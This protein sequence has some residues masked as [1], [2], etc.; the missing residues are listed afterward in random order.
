MVK[1]VIK[2]SVF[3]LIFILAISWILGFEFITSNFKISKIKKIIPID[4]IFNVKNKSSEFIDFEFSLI[5]EEKFKLKTKEVIFQKFSN[6][7]L[8]YRYYLNQDEENLILITNTGKMYFSPKKD[9]YNEN[10]ISLNYIETNLEKIIGKKYINE[11]NFIIKGILILNKKVYISYLNNKNECY[12]NAIVVGDLNIKKI[13]FLPFLKL[14]E[15]KDNFTSAVGGNIQSFKNNKILLTIGGYESYETRGKDDPQNIDSYYGKILAIDLNTKKID[16]ISMGHR[17]SQGLFYDFNEDIIFSTDHGPQ[18][19]DEINVYSNPEINKIKNYGW[20][21]S[22]YGE[23]YGYNEGHS[24]KIKNDISLLDE[25]YKIAPLNKSH[26][27]FNFEE[28]IKYFIPSI[29][30]TQILRVDNLENDDYK[31]LVGSLGFDKTEGVMTVH[32][33]H[34]NSVFKETNHEKIYIGERIRDM[35]D[36]NNGSILISLDSS[37]SFGLLKDIY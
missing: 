32:I 10:K 9:I 1:K 8:K 28:P 34:F 27:K 35:M 33:L 14:D 19:G 37:G 16:I 13:N 36:L 3:L 31:I 29:A 6:K 26:K 23:H 20:G 5:K 7:F 17:N 22:S 25:L 12:S 21:I 2:Y 30:I 15:C 24:E 4:I 18:G 11:S